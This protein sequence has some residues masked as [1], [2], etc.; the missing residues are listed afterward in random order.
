MTTR[1]QS[2]YARQLAY[3]KRNPWVR[4]LEYARRRCIDPNERS[5][6]SHGGKGVSCL[7]TL[8]EIKTLWER[9][10]AAALK[11]PSL[12]RIDSELDYTFANCRI[13]EHC[14]NIRLPHDSELREK[15]LS[16]KNEAVPDW[17]TEDTIH[18]IDYDGELCEEEVAA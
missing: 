13:I 11:K 3:R 7:I 12:D 5:F 10:N 17:V 15:D 9:D 6:S 4:L 2:I 18:V 14:L 1:P 16:A 8:P